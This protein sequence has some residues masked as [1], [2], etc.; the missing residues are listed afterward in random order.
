M[1]G[2]ILDLEKKKQGLA[3]ALSLPEEEGNIR[4]KVFSELDVLALGRD[5]GVDI[6]IKFLDKIY[7]KDKLSAAY[8]TWTEFDRYKRTENVSV[9]EYVTEFEKLYTKAKKFN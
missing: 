7:K 4:D 8:E 6:L 9:E 1:H 5:D 3:I 2:E